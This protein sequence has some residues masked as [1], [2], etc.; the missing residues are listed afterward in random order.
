[1][2]ATHATVRHMTCRVED[3]GHT[4]FMDNLF[5]SPRLSDDLVRCKINSRP[6][7]RP[8][9]KDMRHDFGLK[10]TKVKR[11][12]ARLKTR[13]G[14]TALVWEEKDRR[15]AILTWTHH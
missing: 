1:M 14:L 4:I 10:Q 9:G 11:G 6:T 2:T 7:E 12:E 13:G 5:S 3:L 15:E 8:N